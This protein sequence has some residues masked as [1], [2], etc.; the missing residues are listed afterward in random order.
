M[1]VSVITPT[2]GWQE[3][4]HHLYRC[5]DNQIYPEKELLIHDDSPEP[6]EGAECLDDPRVLYLHSPERV[7]IGAKRNRLVERASGDLIAHFDHDDYYAPRYLERMIS[8]L[9]DGDLVTLEGWF[10]FDVPSRSLFYWRT[11]EVLPVHYQLTPEGPRALDL[12]APEDRSAWVRR[13]VLGYGFSYVYRSSLAVEVPF[14]EDRV[15]DED[16]AFVEAIVGRGKRVMTFADREGLLLHLIHGAAMST[17]YP[18]HLLPP[19]LVE[20]LFGRGAI[21]YLAEAFGVGASSASVGSWS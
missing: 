5:F 8:A 4:L 18:N 6:W 13:N 2:Y 9:G 10:A 12:S 16:V 14:P 3:Q 1:K 11:A 7:S 19:F 15:H 21:R 20:S 17:I